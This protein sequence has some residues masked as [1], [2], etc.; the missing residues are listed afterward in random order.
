MNSRLHLPSLNI[1]SCFGTS[2]AKDADKVKK[3]NDRGAVAGPS[4]PAKSPIRSSI[5]PRTSLLQTIFR[6]NKQPEVIPKWV[7]DCHLDIDG[8]ED[9]Q[10]QQLKLQQANIGK[11]GNGSVSIFADETGREFAVKT[12]IEEGSTGKKLCAEFENYKTIYLYHKAVKEVKEAKEADLYPEHQNLVEEDDLYPKHRNLVHVY[13]VAKV[14]NEKG[15]LVDALVMDRIPGPDGIKIFKDLKEAYLN[16]K[17]RR[18]GKISHREYWGAIQFI[19]R[20]LLGVIEHMS[21]AGMVHNDIKPGNFIVNEKTGEPVLIDL[22]GCCKK[23]KVASTWTNRFASPEILAR[24]TVDEKSDAF[25]V[26]ATLVGGAEGK[27]IRVPGDITN[28]RAR[29]AFEENR[30][31]RP[32]DFQKKSAYGKFLD[33]LLQEVEAQR[34]SLESAQKLDFLNDS[35]LDDDAAKEVIRNVISPS[36]ESGKSAEA[37][38]KQTTDAASLARVRKKAG[39]QMPL[40]HLERELDKLYETSLSLIKPLRQMLVLMPQIKSG[41]EEYGD[42]LDARTLE[43]EHAELAERVHGML[44]TDALRQ[45]YVKIVN[46]DDTIQDA[47]TSKRVQ[48]RFAKRGGIVHDQKTLMEEYAKLVQ[49]GGNMPDAKAIEGEYDKFAERVDRIQ[50]AMEYAKHVEERVENLNKHLGRLREHVEKVEELLYKTTV[51]TAGVNLATFGKQWKPEVFKNP[52]APGKI[53][54]L[55]EYVQA[56]RGILHDVDRYQPS[57]NTPAGHNVEPELQSIYSMR[58]GIRTDAS[59][60]RGWTQRAIEIKRALLAFTAPLPEDLTH[61][62]PEM[63]E[64]LTKI[65]SAFQSK[66]RE[67]RLYVERVLGKRKQDASSSRDVNEK[68]MMSAKVFLQTMEKEVES[69]LHMLKQ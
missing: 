41:V 23:G 44:D 69:L 37:V 56:A 2:A 53:R 29:E 15:E 46:P 42:R 33:G 66:A 31:Y 61:A 3:G 27:H 26:G 18:E 63:K 8:R 62:S 48:A 54:R 68:D 45:E 4:S 9:P 35:I 57:S 19:T 24:K 28:Q 22:G 43:R 30:L 65:L 7:P 50:G 32:S 51:M 67:E 14:P 55:Q 36:K 34:K 12:L 58:A 13:G 64:N 21:K 17:T 49:L 10:V 1:F 59:A 52:Q 16:K 38:F 20:R 40:P 47:G 5:K 6:K 11:G 39:N 25:A 60:D